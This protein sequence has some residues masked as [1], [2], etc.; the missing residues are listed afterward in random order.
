MAVV[1]SDS[2]VTAEHFA[3]ELDRQLAALNLE[4]ASKRDSERLSAPRVKVTT[5]ESIRKYMES[6]RAASNANQFKFKSHRLDN[7]F[8]SAL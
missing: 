4:Y 6:D 7:G 3:G 5:P 1:E 2:G 8:F